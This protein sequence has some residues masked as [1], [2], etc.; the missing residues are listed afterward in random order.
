LRAERLE[1]IE[2]T[3]AP[4]ALLQQHCQKRQW[5]PPRFERRAMGGQ[6]L[7]SAGICYSVTLE[8]PA[9]NGRKKKVCIYDML[10]FWRCVCLRMGGLT[11]K[12]S[13]HRGMY[14]EA[15]TGRTRCAFCKAIMAF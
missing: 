4:K 11:I 12:A 7:P 9:S 2:E 15:S 1:V 3:K 14:S 10:S 5:P 6:R 13:M 8:L